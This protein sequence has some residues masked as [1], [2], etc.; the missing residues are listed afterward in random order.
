MDLKKSI[1]LFFVTVLIA[2]ALFYGAANLNDRIKNKTDAYIV[3]SQLKQKKEEELAAK[4]QSVYTESSSSTEQDQETTDS[5]EENTVTDISTYGFD[6]A[7]K[8][9]AIWLCITDFDFVNGFVWYNP[10]ENDEEWNR[11]FDSTSCSWVSWTPDYRI[12]TNYSN[13]VLFNTAN[14][15]NDTL[16]LGSAGSYNINNR[17]VD[18]TNGYIAL[19][20]FYNYSVTTKPKNLWFIP[21]YM[22]NLKKAPTLTEK[23]YQYKLLPHRQPPK[24][25]D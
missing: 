18:P 23:G 25:E 9:H 8:D 21:S 12:S 14:S 11:A 19:N 24:A 10:E 1:P 5:E 15:T 3:S 7:R 16:L 13:S 6:N 17:Q 20:V 22:V 4:Q 2:V